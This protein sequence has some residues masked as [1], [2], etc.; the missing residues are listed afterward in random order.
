MILNSPY[1][2]GSI[3]VTGNAN[4]QGTLTVTGSL[5]GTA[6]SASL[7]LNSN[8]LQG[9]GSV[10]FSTT[11]SLLA[12][13]SSQQQISSSLLNVIANYATTGSNSF[14][15]NQSITGS[16]V[17]SSTITAQTLVVQ[18]VTSSIV[19]SSGSNIFGSALT[20]RQTFT[21]SLNVTGSNHNISGNV[22]IGT[23]NSTTKLTIESSTYDDFI[24][25]TRTG[26]GS[27]GISATNPRGIQIT[28]AAGSFVGLSVSASGFVGIGAT[29]PVKTLDVRGTLA[30][31]NNASSY[32]Y[33]DRSDD[34]GRFKILTDGNSEKF[35][36]A[37]TGVAI[38]SGSVQGNA[39]IFS[40][41]GASAATIGGKAATAS[42]LTDKDLTLSAWYPTS[43]TNEYGGDLYLAAGRP[44]GGGSGKYGTVYIQ[45]GIGNGTANVAGSVG[46]VIA[47]NNTLLQFFTATSVTTSPTERI[48]IDSGGDI[49][50]GT[51]TTGAGERLIVAKSEAAPLALNRLS[52]D[53]GVLRFYQDGTEEGNV[54]VAG[55]T[56]SY[57][58]F[59]GSH[60]SQLQDGSKPT[61]LKGTIL[62]VIDEL[63]VWENETNDR[64]PKSKISD[65]IESKNAYGIFLAW[66]EEWES[67]NDF[68]VAA[69]GLGYIRVHSSQNVTIGDLLQSNGDGTAKIQSD[70]IMRSSTIAKV[71][72]TQKIETY[73]DGSY[74]IAATLHCG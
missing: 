65:T 72:S 40:G 71:V 36:I 61:I 30:I 41:T 2:T 50:I 19:Y 4:V 38:F 29:D 47:A 48:R 28:D 16:L 54:T 33:M 32:W 55:T 70:S 5:S 51:Q 7:A 1:I 20:D 43:G 42:G 21:G 34:D 63:C 56:V 57:N 27:M 13:S 59:L 69:V 60:W 37:T 26:V 18:T 66:D 14:R 17:V 25:F 44:T 8:L 15:A 35:S 24:K 6:T 45:A 74:L 64:L 23:T 46:T 12:V 31:S 11:A 52:S 39:G 73:E 49:F 22:G 58:S 62:E 10:G 9:T 67:T 53:G 68:F 3:T